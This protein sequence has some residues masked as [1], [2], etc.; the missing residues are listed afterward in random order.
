MPDAL[1]VSSGVWVGVGA[2]DEA[3]E[4]SGVSHFLEHLLFKGTADR[5]AKSI[6]EARKK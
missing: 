4:M 5:S 6:A 3:R 1:S 2:R